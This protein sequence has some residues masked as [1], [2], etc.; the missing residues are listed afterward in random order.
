M[1]KDCE[2]ALC[3]TLESKSS[4]TKFQLKNQEDSLDYDHGSL[5]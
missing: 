2:N 5:Q 4:E 1:K 3:E